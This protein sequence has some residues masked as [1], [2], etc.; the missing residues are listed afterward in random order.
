MAPK[1]DPQIKELQKRVQRLEVDF[2][3]VVK[4]IKTLEKSLIQELEKKHKNL[5]ANIKQEIKEQTLRDRRDVIYELRAEMLKKMKPLEDKLK[6][7]K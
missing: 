1:P 6:K 2:K 5:G 7:L 4:A 3:Y